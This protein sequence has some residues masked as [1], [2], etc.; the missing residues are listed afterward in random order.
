MLRCIK[1]SMK[2]SSLMSKDVNI[3]SDNIN[4]QKSFFI[5]EGFK[6]CNLSYNQISLNI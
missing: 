6:I 3:K 4:K 5:I 2:K 1:I